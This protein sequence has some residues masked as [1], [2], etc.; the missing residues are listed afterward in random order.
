LAA[1][2][3]K[4]DFLPGKSGIWHYGF[5]EAFMAEMPKIKGKMEYGGN[6]PGFRPD[7]KRVGI[8]GRK[9]MI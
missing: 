4:C 1:E 9:N 2:S 5:S 6:F 7:R 3:R 8:Q